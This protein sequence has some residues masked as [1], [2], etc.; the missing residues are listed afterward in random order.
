[1]SEV[2]QA[3]L[4]GLD[5]SVRTWVVPNGVDTGYFRPADPESVEAE[6]LIFTGTM[7]WEP[8]VDATIHFCGDIFPL[9]QRTYPG[10]RLTIVGAEPTEAVRR[11]GDQRGVTVT[12]SVKDVRQYIGRAAVVIVPIRLGSGT[13]LKILEAMAMGKAVISTAVGCEGLE[14]T[15]GKDIEVANSPEA[16]AVAVCRLLGDPARRRALGEAGRRLVTDRYDW[17]II[18]RQQDAV[19]ATLAEGP[20]SH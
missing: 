8:N 19:Y 2:D 4:R 16:F 10:V 12:G 1:M 20:R 9:I 6:S 11:L 17:R 18:A 5:P 14:V 7:S 13:R 3:A 15:P